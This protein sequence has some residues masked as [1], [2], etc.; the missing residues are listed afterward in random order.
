MVTM[1][2]SYGCDDYSAKRNAN[3]YARARGV[4]QFYIKR[5]SQVIPK[6]ID[7]YFYNQI[8]YSKFFLSLWE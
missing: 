8:M 6:L 3:G 2:P 7:N 1:N 4:I 5:Y